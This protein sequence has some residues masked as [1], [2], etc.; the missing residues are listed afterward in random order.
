MNALH[1][2]EWAAMILRTVLGLVMVAHSLYLK[3]VVFTLPGTAQFFESIGLP[4]PLA[5]LVFTVEALAGLALI[6]G[7]QTRLA[8]LVL[9]PVLLGATWAHLGNGWLFTN[10]G[11][12]WEYPLVLVALA[13]VQ[14]M[15]GSGALAL[16][17]LRP[18]RAVV[19]GAY[20][21]G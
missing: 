5:Y 6:L 9:I 3:L 13:V 4:G 17:N 18:G 12:G 19:S 7:Y 21:S 10:S 16:D 15:L 14:V 2:P 20:T 1:R 11:G 8:A